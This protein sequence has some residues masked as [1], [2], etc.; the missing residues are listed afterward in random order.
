MASGI[1]GQASPAATSNTTVYTVP[2][3]TTASFSISVCNR[4]TSAC[5]VR[6]A[7]AAAATPT[8]SEWIEYDVS[9]PGNSVLERTG[10]VANTGKLV[11]AYASA[12]TTSISIYG[13][14]A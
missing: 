3:A 6:L 5:T 9:V 2:A 12:A 8:N 10:L 11:V 1:L 4:D 7:I 13:F 14:E